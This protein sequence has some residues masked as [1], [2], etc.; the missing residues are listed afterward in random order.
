[1]SSF[2]LLKLCLPCSSGCGGCRKTFLLST[3]FKKLSDLN[4][5]LGESCGVAAVVVMIGVAFVF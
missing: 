4:T 5:A 1:M 3:S 2:L